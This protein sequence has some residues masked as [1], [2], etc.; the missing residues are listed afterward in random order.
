MEQRFPLKET[1]CLALSVGGCS[2]SALGV[3]L[4]SHLFR[5]KQGIC[6]WLQLI[7]SLGKQPQTLKRQTARDWKC[8]PR[9]IFVGLRRSV[10]G[11]TV[12]H[13]QMDPEPQKLSSLLKNIE[14]RCFSLPLWS[15]SFSRLNIKWEVW[16]S[17]CEF[18]HCCLKAKWTVEYFLFLTW[19]FT[20]LLDI[21]TINAMWS[22]YDHLIQM[23]PRG[24]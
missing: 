13:P 1:E 21:H 10:L 4:H 17:L 3:H 9:Q 19:C 2:K 24:Q 5:Q 11:E 16:R 22:G 6:K 18:H 14:C 20:F 12:T 7:N 23:A 8:P 15:Y